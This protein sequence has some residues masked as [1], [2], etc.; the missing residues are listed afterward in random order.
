MH[1]HV[2]VS[3][4]IFI[5]IN[6]TIFQNTFIETVCRIGIYTLAEFEAHVSSHKECFTTVCIKCNQATNK[7]SIGQHLLKCFNKFGNFQCVF[8]VFGTNV[9]SAIDNHLSTE[10]PDKLSYFAERSLNVSTFISKFIY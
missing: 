8:C 2:H 7:S 3:R 1:F 10:H 5:T 9:F 6:F 4:I